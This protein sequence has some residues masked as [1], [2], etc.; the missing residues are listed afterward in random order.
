MISSKIEQSRGHDEAGLT[1]VEITIVTVLLGFLSLI[2]FGSL[3]GI[4]RT[5][6]AL[7]SQSQ[8]LNVARTFFERIGR[9][10]NNRSL[11][12]LVEHEDQLGSSFRTSGTGIIE[13]ISDGQGRDSLTF[14]SSETSQSSSSAFSNHG[15]VQIRYSLKRDPRA[16]EEENGLSLIRDEILSGS[17]ETAKQKSRVVFP[18]ASGVEALDFRFYHNEQWTETWE[19]SQL[20][21]VVEVSLKLIEKDGSLSS[22]RTAFAVRA[23][24]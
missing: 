17:Q 8:T 11:E 3:D 7:N 13:G 20:P 1:F 22:F 15:I 5:R 14:T 18:I 23:G 4:V 16:E 12:L 19:S 10:L 6:E 2:A 9:E 24:T 21:D